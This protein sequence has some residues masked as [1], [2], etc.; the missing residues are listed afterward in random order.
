VT[1]LAGVTCVFL[2]CLVTDAFML[3]GAGWGESGDAGSGLGLP[4]CPPAL[5]N[6]PAAPSPDPDATGCPSLLL[7]LQAAGPC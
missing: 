3:V 7:P 5:L 6:L 2:W 4:A 1:G